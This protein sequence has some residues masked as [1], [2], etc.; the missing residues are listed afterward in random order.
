MSKIKS[1]FLLSIISV[2]V[3]F[4]L[5]MTFIR[6]PIGIRNYNSVL[7]A[8][9]LDYDL[10]GGTAYN[11][12]LS[13]D[14]E[15]EI[16]DIDQVIDTLKYRLSELGYNLYSV[17]AIKS[18]D[19]TV[20]DYDI[21][22]ET[23]TTDTLSSDIEVVA[24]HGVVKLYGGTSANPTTEILEDVLA[25]ADSQ[26]HGMVSNGEETY[27]QVSITFTQDGYNGLVELM[28]EAE[29]S[30][31]SYY[32][33]IKLGD[34]VLLSGSE[35]IS[36]TDFSNKTLNV[37]LSSETYAKQI[38]L[39]M[40]TGGLAQLYDIS[41]PVSISSPYGSNVATRAAIVIGIL[42]LILFIALVVL[43]RGLGVIGALSLLLFILLETLMLIAVPGIILSM[44]G[45]VGIIM[46]TLVTA[47][48]VAYVINKVK[49]EYAN[50]E[51]TVV[52]SIKKA[53][54]DCLR[55]VLNA[56]VVLGIVT[57]LLLAFTSGL[58]N[59]FAV[60]FGIGIVIGLITTLL[61]IRMY[62]Y[63]IL[64]LVKNKEEFFN[65]KRQEV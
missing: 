27:Y 50:S 62:T 24:A 55:P 28:N 29:S 43:Y 51:K 46:S 61:F 47:F 5:V 44:G 11:L 30:D 32:L 4:V 26:Y 23:R 31:S 33:E 60:T 34:K 21:R 2:L 53:F 39:Q 17:K 20:K 18:T 54:K 41:D 49:T 37:Y 63:L 59:C 6:F 25:I 42:V 10:Q 48:G 57:I 14:N 12:T 64:P 3:T 36:K 52:A 38:A 58:A 56:G 16:E 7:G 15:E 13:E 65:L 35:A 19:A 40:R 45:V 1:I 22:I 9:E 8:I